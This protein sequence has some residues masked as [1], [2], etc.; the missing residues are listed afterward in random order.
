MKRHLLEQLADAA[1]LAEKCR[2][3]K[4]N[5]VRN[6]NFEKAADLREGEKDYL[7]VID[8]LI[9]ELTNEPGE[10]KAAE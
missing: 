4:I 2:Q 7:A 5:A 3:E 10:N 1:R 9:E 8:V 6:Q